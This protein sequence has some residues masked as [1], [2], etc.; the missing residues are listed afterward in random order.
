MVFSTLIFL[1]VFLPPVLIGTWALGWLAQWRGTAR[2]RAADHRWGNLWLLAASL[3]FYFWGEG[4]GVLWLVGN[5]VFNAVCAA[6]LASR[7]SAGWRKGWLAAAIV[8]DLGMLGWFKYAGF[9]ASSI[10]LIPGVEIPVPAVAL[11]LG[12][13]FYTF[14]AMSYVIDV[15]RG[16][17]ERAHGILNFAC[18]ITMFPQLVA[19]PIV[20]YVDIEQNLV[21]RST[22]MDRIASGMRRFLVGLVKKAVIANTVAEFADAAWQYADAGTIIPVDAAWLAV[23]AYTIQIYYDFS[24]YSDMA[25]GIGRMLGFDFLEN[26]R[27]PYCSD[28]IREFWRRWHISL[29]TW[30]RDYLYIPLGG[31]RKGMFRT[32]LNSLI[33]FA[34]CGLW[35]GASAMFVIWGLWHGFF[36]MAER[37]LGRKKG[38]EKGTE[39]P[40]GVLARMGGHVYATAVFMAGWVLFRS[41]TMSSAAT[42]FKSLFGLGEPGRETALLYVDAAPKF[43]V[44]LALGV[45]FAYPIVPALRSFVTRKDGSVAPAVNAAAWVLISVSAVFAV[46]LIAGGSYNPFIYFRF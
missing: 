42:I 35:H 40:R 8:G 33:V 1:T 44:A 3:V 41:E 37:L 45:L 7:P 27:H 23:V 10:N 36:L 22:S 17:V 34:L 5:V 19:G 11:P 13:S 21:S 6:M 32:C 38:Q 29:S 28:S 14:Q 4:W 15:Y 20:R 39:R 18:Y 12:I 24:G 30:F 31:N 2:G 16:E 26:F 9:A 25:I 46:L 43:L